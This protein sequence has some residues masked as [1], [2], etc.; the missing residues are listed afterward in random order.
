MVK[1]NLTIVEPEIR[2]LQDDVQIKKLQEIIKTIEIEK[3]DLLSK[4]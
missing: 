2:Y 1:E 3:N 4:I